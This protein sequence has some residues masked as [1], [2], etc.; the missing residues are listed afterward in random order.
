MSKVIYEWMQNLAF[1]FILMTAILNCL[2]ENQ[3]RK[4]V[5]FFLGLVLLIVLC[6]PLLGILNLDQILSEKLSS[7]T[8]EQEALNSRNSVLSVEG[9]QEN[10]LNQAYEREIEGQIQVM[11]E[12][13]GI[14]VQE[15]DVQL[16]QGEQVSVEQ[17]TLRVSNPEKAMYR[18][19]EEEMEK[20][21]GQKLE[22]V[23]SEL[24]QVYATEVSHINIERMQ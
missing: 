19:E 5:Q 24:A 2:P 14:N 6:K 8:L 13:R 17:I 11:M 4:Y 15:A 9:V 20:D 7:E 23:K 16:S 22:D 1:F 10:L 3:Y 18:E 12:E 21:F